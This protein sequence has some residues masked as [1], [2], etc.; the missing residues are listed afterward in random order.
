VIILSER[1]STEKNIR[2]KARDL[3]GDLVKKE[4]PYVVEK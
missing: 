4:I 2:K 3:Q 1:T